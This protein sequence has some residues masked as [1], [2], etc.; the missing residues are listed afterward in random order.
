MNRRFNLA[1]NENPDQANQEQQHRMGAG[2]FLIMML[3]FPLQY[4]LTD[5]HGGN[6]FDQNF[7]FHSNL[8]SVGARNQNAFTFIKNTRYV[9]ENYLTPTAI[10]EN[11]ANLNVALENYVEHFENSRKMTKKQQNL[12][13]SEGETSR[14]MTPGYWYS[15]GMPQSGTRQYRSTFRFFDKSR[16][17]INIDTIQ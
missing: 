8:V 13:Y 1:E 6:F 7:L 11:L 4:Y 16:F 12:L 10:K 17:Y 3:A 9:V 15:P 2:F 5:S 14:K